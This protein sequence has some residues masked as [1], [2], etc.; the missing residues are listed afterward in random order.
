MDLIVQLVMSELEDRRLPAENRLEGLKWLEKE[1][2]FKQTLTEQQIQ[3][4]IELENMK[5]M[6]DK[7]DTVAE[8]KTVISIIKSIYDF[9][10]RGGYDRD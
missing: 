4:Y 5:C 7:R 6:S 9:V 8:I 2:K 10:L 1:E 3:T